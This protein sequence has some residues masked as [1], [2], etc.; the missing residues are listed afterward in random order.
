MR[1]GWPCQSIHCLESVKYFPRFLR[2]NEVIYLAKYAKVSNVKI[3][4]LVT[5][6]KPDWHLHSLHIHEGVCMT[7]F[8]MYISEVGMKYG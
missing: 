7:T 6:S 4:N 8:Y 1:G 2:F 5:F 3:C